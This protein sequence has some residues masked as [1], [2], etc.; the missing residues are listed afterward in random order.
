MQQTLE[1][2]PSLL[3]DGDL[4]VS[5]NKKMLTY[6]VRSA[7]FCSVF[8]Q[9]SA[10][11]RLRKNSILS[12]LLSVSMQGKIKRDDT[13]RIVSLSTCAVR[14]LSLLSM[15]ESLFWAGFHLHAMHPVPHPTYS[16]G[17]TSASTSQSR[18]LSP[19]HLFFCT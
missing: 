6:Q 8:L 17:S 13:S 11:T 9:L 16:I 19:F 2:F 12:N 3:S 14:L 10:I 7:C 5:R 1:F 18:C 15:L 4:G